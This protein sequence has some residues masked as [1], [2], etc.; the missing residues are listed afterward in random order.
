MFDLE[1]RC[2]EQICGFRRLAPARFRP[3]GCDGAAVAALLE[4]LVLACQP[5]LRSSEGWWAL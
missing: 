2:P 3:A 5:K 1:N 4:T